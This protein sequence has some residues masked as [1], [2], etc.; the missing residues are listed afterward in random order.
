MLSLYPGRVTINGVAMQA[1]VVVGKRGIETADGGYVEKRSLNV[2]I[3][4]S[5]LRTAPDVGECIRHDGEIYEIDG[6]D[7][8]RSLCPAWILTCIESD[9]TGK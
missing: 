3:P 4:K 6:V 7:G 8:H 9:R 1:G 2:Q 5:T